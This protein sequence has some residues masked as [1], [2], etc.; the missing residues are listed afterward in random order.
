MNYIT[1]TVPVTV[2]SFTGMVTAMIFLEIN[3]V[4][5][6]GPMV[7]PLRGVYPILSQ[8]LAKDVETLLWP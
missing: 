1:V 3:T 6:A 7:L 8:S 5:N 4:M 2:L